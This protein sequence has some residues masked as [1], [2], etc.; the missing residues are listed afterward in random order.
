M[1]TPAAAPI[2]ASIQLNESLVSAKTTVGW[3]PTGFVNGGSFFGS[4]DTGSCGIAYRT[5]G[6]SFFGSP[7][8]SAGAALA[9]A[10][11]TA[12]TVE[13]MRVRIIVSSLLLPAER[14]LSRGGC[15]EAVREPLQMP[16]A[17]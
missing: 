5:K 11:T 13:V 10:I 4:P 12:A 15:V 6:P 2:A 3:S 9:A 17:R 8:A 7:Y 1:P 16:A 14:G